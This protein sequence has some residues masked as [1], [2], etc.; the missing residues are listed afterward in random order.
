MTEQNL[1]RPDAFFGTVTIAG[2]TCSSRDCVSEPVAALP[3]QIHEDHASVLWLCHPHAKV[4]VARAGNDGTVA[5]ISRTC[6]ASNSD[7]PCGAAATHLAV[8]DV[9]GVGMRLLSVCDRHAAE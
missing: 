8:V 9:P 3:W 4:V 2:K 7:A 6:G 1:S 5:E